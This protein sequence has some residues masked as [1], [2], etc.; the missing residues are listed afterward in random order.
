MAEY[1]SNSG[2]YSDLEI[3]EAIES[4]HIVQ[5]PSAP[6]LINNSSVDVRL[7]MNFYR[8]DQSTQRPGVYNP[9]DQDDID[10]YFGEPLRA[11]PLREQG[12][13]HRRLGIS[14][15]KGI[16]EDYPVILLRPG[17]RILAHTHEFIG[18]RTP[19]TSSMHAKSTTGRNGVTVCKDAGWGD[20]GYINRWTMEIQNENEDEYVPLPFGMLIA[21]IVFHH[22]GIQKA[23]YAELTG[24]YQT[25]NDLDEIVKNWKVESMRPVPKKF[26]LPPPIAQVGYQ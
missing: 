17:E 25:S 2:I 20:G 13:F 22:T 3:I 26:Q 8:T 21:Q 5:Y 7:G 14:A 18:I 10:R 23:G 1:V 24:N 19:G 16:S 6:E 4:G 9:Y 11:E 15:L 12:E